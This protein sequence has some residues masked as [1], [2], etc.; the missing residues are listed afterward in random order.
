MLDKEPE[1]FVAAVRKWEILADFNKI[2]Q[3]SP[4]AFLNLPEL[5]EL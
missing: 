3:L 1:N 2:A 5:D 4:G